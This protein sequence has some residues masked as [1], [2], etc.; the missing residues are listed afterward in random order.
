[1]GNRQIGEGRRKHQPGG[2]PPPPPSSL[3]PCTGIGNLAE[4]SSA[5]VSSMI[6]SYVSSDSKLVATKQREV[7]AGL[8]LYTGC[9]QGS[10]GKVK[11]K[12]NPHPLGSHGNDYFG[13]LS[14]SLTCNFRPVAAYR[15]GTAMA[16]PHLWGT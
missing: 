14:A 9:L 13:G 2:S 6:Q 10:M 16:V 12:V 4:N 1:M 7:T 3:Y 15:A 8:R 11:T 5:I